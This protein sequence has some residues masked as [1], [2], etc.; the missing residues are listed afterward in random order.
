M[1]FVVYKSSAG[2]GKTATLVL[3][4][5]K[6]CLKNPND[7]K[8]TLAITFTNKAA[9]EM[10][11][12]IIDTLVLI[13]NAENSFLT[14]LLKEHLKT[15][16][17]EF[18]KRGKYLL[19]LITHNYDEFSVS[20]IDSFVHKIIRTFTN[21]LN[22]PSN[23]EIIL[24]KDDLIPEIL[25]D[26]Y[27]KIG[28]DKQLTDILLS[29][30][31]K[32]IEDEKS[33]NIS[34]ILS[35]FVNYNL[36][37]DVFAQKKF[38]NVLTINDFIE[39]IK[40]L[41]KRQKHLKNDIQKYAKEAIN[42]FSS[43]SLSANDISYKEKGIY[44][45]FVKLQDISSAKAILPGKRNLDTVE[46]DKWVSKNANSEIVSAMDEIKQSL[47]DIFDKMVEDVRVYILLNII[48]S[49]IYSVA[50]ITVIQ[51]L[52]DEF[53][54]RS[55]KVHISEFNKKISDSIAGQPIP[56]IYERLGF[57]Y[58]NFLIDEFQDTSVL[59]WNN[60]LP[61]VEE[62]LSNNNFS[63]L[64]GDAKQAI[65]RFRNGEVELFSN[66]PK[67]Y[68]QDD[69]LLGQS[70]EALLNSQYRE[71]VLDYNYRSGKT[72]VEF[73]N[74][75]FSDLIEGENEAIKK[76][77]TNLEQKPIRQ[78]N[79]YVKLET[80]EANNKDEFQ[81]EKHLKIESFISEAI[82]AGFQA[83]DICVLG[84]RKKSISELANYLISKN[85]KVV[86]S[87]SLLVNNSPK[88]SMIVS[89]LQMITKPDEKI[90]LADFII[91]YAELKGLS[92]TEELLEEI[93]NHSG[94]TYLFVFQMFDGKV[95]V[96]SLLSYSLYEVCEFA[97]RLLNF[98]K[99][100]D[101]FLQFFLDFVFKSQNS[102]KYTIIEFL[103]YWNEKKTKIFVSTPEKP[104][105]IKLMTAHK[106]KGLAFKVVI[107][108][109]NDSVSNNS[110]TIWADVSKMH[111]PKLSKTLIPLTKQ[112]AEVGF[113]DEYD[114]EKEKE[115]LDFINLV[116]VSFTRA[117]HALFVVTSTE[118]RNQYGKIIMDFISKNSKNDN[119]FEDGLLKAEPAQSK[120]D[121]YVNYINLDV[122]PSVDLNRI[123]KIARSE[124]ISWNNIESKSPEAY[125]NLIHRILSE[126]ETFDDV[127][128][129]LEKYVN[130]GFITHPEKD[131]LRTLIIEIVE[132][133]KL[134]KYF[135][136]S[137][138]VK[139]ESEVYDGVG[140]ILRPDRLAILDDE[141]AIIDYKTGKISQK[142]HTQINEYY[143]VMKNIGYEKINCFLVYISENIEVEHLNFKD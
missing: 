27:R 76:H 133:Q 82:E 134:S 54:D 62:S 120:D 87:E 71:E 79:S 116:Y 14:T 75:F 34:T 122:Y 96:G 117:S 7:F 20:T 5:L 38:L 121:E 67:L 88:V 16:D 61:L 101:I 49:K 93:S 98:D 69:S 46:N 130:F 137:A 107:A 139:N 39:I 78:Q 72:I 66:L 47:T 10:K 115:N 70:R 68:P 21:E 51:S 58:K 97:I 13:S 17:D 99:E 65:Y 28:H 36:S 111:I 60:L 41:N 9:N 8:R 105:A 124:Q 22:L 35:S 106:S 2:S 113:E 3:E 18:Q 90:F 129:V 4:Y 32:Q 110:N 95:D 141:L 123:V 86:S 127:E 24:D 85:Y 1:A 37:E 59:Q 83:G 142:Y 45:Y 103:E 30:V 33:H 80:V 131:K 114:K 138:V 50:L 23:F 108:D 42:L 136:K 81:P 140:N 74:L 77:Y 63:M 126:I 26:L 25:D 6:L 55:S 64:V 31:F 119:L 100:A 128:N 73:N 89:L 102:T 104:D 118:K 19:N 94:E 52:F 135:S 56:F 132:H 53:V 84:R 92:N 11:S 48:N 29:F 15:S 44:G 125:G 57:K 40:I 112:T 143:A 43:V 109:L 91:K 12:R